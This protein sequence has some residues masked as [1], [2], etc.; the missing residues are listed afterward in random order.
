[1][2][3][4]YRSSHAWPVLAPIILPPGDRPHAPI[5][6]T[7]TLGRGRAPDNE[8]EDDDDDDKSDFMAHN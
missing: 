5:T 3:G 7:H 1:M 6:P 4:P 2:P 8:E